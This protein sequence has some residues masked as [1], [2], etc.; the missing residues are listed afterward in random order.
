MY[1]NA[2]EHDSEI[3]TSRLKKTA[4]RS[5]QFFSVPN[6]S[7][8]EKNN[9]YSVCVHYLFIIFLTTVNFI[10]DFNLFFQ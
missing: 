10:V 5:F 1:L 6:L 9:F 8:E 4:I 7:S 2:R 3:R